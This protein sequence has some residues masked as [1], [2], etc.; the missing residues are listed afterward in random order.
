MGEEQGFKDAAAHGEGFVGGAA[1]V[2][3]LA[4]GVHVAA[5]HALM[6]PDALRQDAPE[7]AA[8]EAGDGRFVHVGYDLISLDLVAD[9]AEGMAFIHSMSSAGKPEWVMKIRS[10]TMSVRPSS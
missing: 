10:R 5:L 4:A 6:D 8:D 7:G 1:A 9:G 2:V 3:Q